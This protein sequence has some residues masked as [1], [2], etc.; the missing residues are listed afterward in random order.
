MIEEKDV[1]KAAAKIKVW[2]IKVLEAMGKNYENGD[3]TT[4][5]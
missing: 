4:W 3:V 1:K 2:I 5:L